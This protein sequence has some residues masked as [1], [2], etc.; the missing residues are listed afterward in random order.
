MQNT[1]NVLSILQTVNTSFYIFTNIY[2]AYTFTFLFTDFRYKQ[3]HLF[4]NLQYH[5]LFHY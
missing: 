2:Y 5:I 1:I 4:V 3:L